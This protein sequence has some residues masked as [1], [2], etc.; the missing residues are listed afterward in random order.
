MQAEQHVQGV[1]LGARGARIDSNATRKDR[2]RQAAIQRF[3]DL[4]DYGEGG[5]E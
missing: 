2:L 5:G 4:N 3:N 1:G